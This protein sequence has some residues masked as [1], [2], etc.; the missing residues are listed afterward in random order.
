MVTYAFSPP[1]VEEG[2]AS[3]ENRLFLRVKLTRGVS[4]LEGPPGVFR[5]ARF[6]TQD[7]IAA[8]QPHMFMGGHIYEVDADTRAALI[9]ANIGV[10]DANFQSP[11]TGFGAG[12]FG[13]GAFGG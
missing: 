10:T 3:W 5:A 4:I 9:A 13:D 1:T 2:P 7:E 8:S 11:F 6:P 12:L